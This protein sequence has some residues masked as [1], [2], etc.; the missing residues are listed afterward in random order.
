MNEP[1]R[2]L[3]TGE[4]VTPHNLPV[5]VAF[6]QD[7]IKKLRAVNA[8]EESGDSARSGPDEGSQ[9]A[10]VKR[11][12]LVRKLSVTLPISPAPTS[13]KTSDSPQTSFRDS[14]TP[15][16]VAQPLT[17][18]SPSAL[19][20]LWRGLRNVHVGEDSQFMRLGG[21][22][23]APQSTSSSI[24]VALSYSGFMEKGA[25]PVLMRLRIR[26]FMDQGVDLRYLS[27]YPG[28]DECLYPPLTYLA[29][30]GSQQITVPLKGLGRS[31]TFTVVTVVPHF[32]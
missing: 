32:S 1:L 10:A 25:R 27:S 24:A 20:D 30:K 11:K 4:R 2:G 18:K 15:Y 21:T 19:N 8:P 13:Q 26:T 31:V 28:E 29:P 3:A 12:S 5:T 9:G 17:P 7:S 23:Y 6:I 16:L 22:D 14:H